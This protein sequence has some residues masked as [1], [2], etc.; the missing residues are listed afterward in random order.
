MLKVIEKVLVPSR[1]TINLRSYVTLG[2]V[3]QQ[4]GEEE[5]IRSSRS[6]KGEVPEAGTTTLPSSGILYTHLP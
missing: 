6:S 1:F 3:V 5:A 2:A 4:G